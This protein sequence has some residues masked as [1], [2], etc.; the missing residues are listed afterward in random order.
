MISLK[1]LGALHEKYLVQTTF[2]NIN[3]IYKLAMDNMNK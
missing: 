2:A 3:K 1:L